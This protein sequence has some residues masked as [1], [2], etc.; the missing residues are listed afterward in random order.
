MSDIDEIDYWVYPLLQGTAYWLG[1]SR[2]YYSDHL[3]KEGAIV[4]EATKLIH[5]RL[6]PN[7]KLNC[8]KMYKDFI[9]DPIGKQEFGQKR[10]DITIS[11]NESL[12]HLIEVKRGI[13]IKRNIKNDLNRLS[14]AQTYISD[15]RTFLLLISERK[16]PDKYVSKDGYAKTRKFD[17]KEGYFKVR[18]VCKA[19]PS[20]KKKKTANYSCL[21]EV[22]NN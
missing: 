16:L 3:L 20:F 18:R 5:S 7:E 9:D 10:V 17:L 19:A 22:F 13:A 2:M 1:H 8:E 21:I 12:K 14:K 4:A 15:V 11:Q 6:K